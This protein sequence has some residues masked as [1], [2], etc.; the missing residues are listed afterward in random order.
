MV[1]IALTTLIAVHGV[2]HLF[3]FLKAFHLIKFD[4]IAQPVS[5][6]FG[7]IWLVAFFLFVVTSVLF[8][9]QHRLWWAPGLAAV[10][11][12]QLLIFAFWQDA[13][14]GT[15][16]NV[17]ILA[18]A[19]ISYSGYSFKEQVNE[20]IVEMVALSE[21]ADKTVVSKEMI[22]HLPAIVQRWFVHSGA[23]GMARVQ[24]VYLEQE[25]KM[26]L[27]PEQKNWTPAMARQY[28][29]VEPPAFNWSV[30]LKMN[31]FIDVTGRDKFENGKG[32]MVIKLLSIIPVANARN[33]EKIDQATLQRYLAEIV[34]F[35]SAAL[36]P[37]ISWE[38]VDDTS[39][40]A[41][42]DYMGTKGSGVFHFDESG[43][44]K[45]FVA[46]RFK[47]AEDAEPAKWTVIATKTEER[48]G[49]KIPTK[50]EATWEMENGDWTWLKLRVSHIQTNNQKMPLVKF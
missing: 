25:V 37:Y 7:M 26:R 33:S 22:A 39:A 47:G 27:K 29:T 49:I 28:F 31:G 13:K 9:L 41:T 36:S 50:C 20:E 10:A 14:F 34:W 3:G 1:R 30:D 43:N 42:I 32:E 17:F 4:A 12:S 15:V 19:I 24:N 18:S 2:I 23:V 45:K 8:L 46:M 38:K 21:N 5:K 6:A 35:P 16:L 48:N 44:F 40:K 11:A